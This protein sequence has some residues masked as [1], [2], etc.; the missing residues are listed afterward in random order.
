M[1]IQWLT[2]SLSHVLSVLSVEPIA[3]LYLFAIFGEYTSVNDLIF[4]NNCRHYLNLNESENECSIGKNQT[5]ELSAIESQTT[6][7]LIYYNSLLAITSIFTS[8]IA[9]SFGDSYGR[10]IPLMVP[11]ILSFIVQIILIITSIGIDS[12]QTIVLI[13]ICAFISGI[14]GGS[15]NFLA[16]CF[17]FIS[18]ITEEKERTRRLVVL[19]ANIF[20]GAFFGYTITGLI[21]KNFIHYKYIICFT[22][23]S[24]IHLFIIFYIWFRLRSFSSNSTQN[25]F[26]LR[27]ILKNLWIMFTDVIKTVFRRRQSNKRKLIFLLILNFI[28][29]TYGTVVLSTILYVFLRNRPLLWDT[30]KYAYYNGFKFGATGL[31]LCSLPLVQYYCLANIC[32]TSIAIIGVLSRT[33]GL[34]LI[35]FATNDYIVFSTIALFVFSE[36]PLPV[37][38]SL[39]SKLVAT[40]E[41]GKI[42]AFLTLFYNLCQLSGG[43]LFPIIYK[44]EIN[45][46]KNPGLCFQ[47]TAGLEIIAILIFM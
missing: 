39:L 6:Q 4:F 42:F 27:I 16:N 41:R 14:S 15:A 45:S 19:E 31:A 26:D 9:G 40:D 21:F 5:E 24:S 30:S 22:I 18:D 20:C 17:G 12:K 47:I 7:Q 32:D 2:I 43:I 1:S 46:G 29:V 25:S 28:L 33:L 23:Y 38:R 3:F 10:I 13:L 34:I 8:F 36:Y 37:I 11:P 44:Y 35:S